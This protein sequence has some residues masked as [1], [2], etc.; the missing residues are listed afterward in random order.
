MCIAMEYV[1]GGEL[2]D[3]ISEKQGLS[4]TE[5]RR[6]FSQIACAVQHCHSVSIDVWHDV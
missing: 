1:S 3:Y 4:E 5:A 2:F 6:L